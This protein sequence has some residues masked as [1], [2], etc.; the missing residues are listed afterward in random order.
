MHKPPHDE[1]VVRAGKIR[2]D[3]FFIVSILALSLSGC[4]SLGGTSV[5]EQS[6]GQLL[7]RDLV[8][9]DPTENLLD[10]VTIKAVAAN[11]RRYAAGSKP[12]VPSLDKDRYGFWIILTISP[13]PWDLSFDPR[14]VLLEVDPNKT[15]PAKGFIG[16]YKS[17]VCYPTNVLDA[18][19]LNS[20]ESSFPIRKESC[21]GVFFETPPLSPGEPFRVILK[22]LYRSGKLIAPSTLQIHKR[23]TYFKT[24]PAFMLCFHC[25]SQRTETWVVDE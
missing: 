14:Q 25:G 19:N 12:Q 8:G 18:Q 20:T 5:T 1:T 16:P 23:T 4:V 7:Y 13:R 22:G 21:I 6:V 24:Y 11:E 10:R 9:N 2:A 15:V 3:A 17:E